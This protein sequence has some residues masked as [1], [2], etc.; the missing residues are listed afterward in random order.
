MG[1]ISVETFVLLVRVPLGQVVGD[2]AQLVV[3]L[4]VALLVDVDVRGV[5]LDALDKVQ[6]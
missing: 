2:L 3:V 5:I 4:S 1:E 6:V